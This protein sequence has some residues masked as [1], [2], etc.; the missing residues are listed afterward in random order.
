MVGDCRRGR[1]VI[2]SV[3]ASSGAR[4]LSAVFGGQGGA[5]LGGAVVLRGPFALGFYRSPVLQVA[6]LA[7]CRA[8]FLASIGSV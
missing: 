1:A 2:V 7:R 3:P 8:L 5:R 4:S 6:W